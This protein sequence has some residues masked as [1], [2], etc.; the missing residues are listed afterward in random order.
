MEKTR[1]ALLLLL[2][3]CG[4]ALAYDANG[5]V[6]GG[7][8]DDVKKAFPSARCQAL[9]WKSKAAERRCDDAKIVFAGGVQARVTFYL[10]SG[11]VEAFDVRFNTGDLERVTAFLK[12]QYGAPQGESRDAIQGKDG[13]TERRFYKA[14]W[15]KKGGGK[16]E[17]AVLTAELEKSRSSL[18][19]SRGDFEEEI[20]RVR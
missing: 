17:H 9:E 8:E 4:P 7:K 13:K 6:L 10:K 2:L 11:V 3:A 12:K 20:Y 5:V 15:E 16:P 18:L 14:R 19:A 1:L